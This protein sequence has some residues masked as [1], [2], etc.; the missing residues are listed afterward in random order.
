MIG[1]CG[2]KY[3]GALSAPQAKI[4]A[5]RDGLSLVLSC[6]LQV[7]FVECDAINVD[8]E[9]N[10]YSFDSAFKAIIEDV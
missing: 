2:R 10:S 4:M 9:V 5:H 3:D 7:D 1:F 8:N 6:G